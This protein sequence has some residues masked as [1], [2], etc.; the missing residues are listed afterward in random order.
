LTSH[1]KTISWDAQFHT[2]AAPL[3]RGFQ[4][5]EAAQQWAESFAQKIND[6][7]LKTDKHNS[8]ELTVNELFDS[9][10]NTSIDK[11]ATAS[12]T[13]IDNA[14]IDIL[15][16]ALEVW[17]FSFTTYYHIVLQYFVMLLTSNDNF[18]QFQFMTELSSN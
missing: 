9:K 12:S 17:T 18:R 11:M 1:F 14:D 4:I 10:D 3:F 6:H 2:I 13:S 16:A 15:L 7:I 5:P 8:A